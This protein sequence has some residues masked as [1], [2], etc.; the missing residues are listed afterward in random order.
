MASILKG[1]VAKMFFKLLVGLKFYLE[2]GQEVTKLN[3]KDI[4]KT[5]KMMDPHDTFSD[6]KIAA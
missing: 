3:I 4:M 5:Y 6:G 2:T 1:M